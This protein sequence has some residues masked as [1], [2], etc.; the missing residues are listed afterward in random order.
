LSDHK[1]ITLKEFNQRK[2]R[3]EAELNQI[4]NNLDRTVHRIK[5]SFLE[6]VIPADKIRRKPFKSIGIAIIVGFAAGLPK[7]KKKKSGKENVDTNGK[8][9]IS[10][11][12]KDELR[13]LVAQKTAGYIMDVIDSKLSS[14]L[15]PD[16][17][18]DSDDGNL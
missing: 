2:N 12:L 18:S 10:I 3:I 5:D 15:K 17:K 14:S 1:N 7:I 11:L 16:N 13:R 9:G 4:Q 6:S 8:P